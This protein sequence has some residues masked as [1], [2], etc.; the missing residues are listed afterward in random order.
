[1]AEKESFPP[2]ARNVS[3]RVMR[4][5]RSRGYVSLDASTTSG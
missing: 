1:M 5:N 4:T 2:G 3:T